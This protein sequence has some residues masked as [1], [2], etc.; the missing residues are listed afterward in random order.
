MIDTTIPSAS[1]TGTESHTPFTEKNIGKIKI[2]PI[3]NIK[4]LANEIRAETFPSE[5]AVNIA[6]AKILKPI[7]RKLRANI[8]KP[9]IVMANTL[10]VGFVKIVK[11]GLRIIMDNR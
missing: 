10:V 11:A 1:A 7:S 4:V 5:R 2:A 8:G 6:D 3:K 9:S